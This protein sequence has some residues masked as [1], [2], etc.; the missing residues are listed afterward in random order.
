MPIAI[1]DEQL[2]I[3]ASI[4]EWAKRAGTIELVR[5]LEPGGRAD[6]ADAAAAERWSN[7]AD[8]GIFS[9]GLLQAAA[10]DA[11]SPAELAAALAQ[12]T[13]SLVPG[14]VMPTLL[15][16]LVLAR[17]QAQRPHPAL[18][19]IAGGDISV[20]TA[21]E[22]GSVRAVGR[23]DG[24]LALTGTT[25]PIL[26][27]GSTTHV[28][29]GAAG[30]DPGSTGTD[31]GTDTTGTDTTGT[32]TTGTD[33]TG[34]DTVG[35]ADSGLWFLLPADHPGI[36]ISC[37]EPADFSRTLAEVS[38]A[39]A[40]A[41]S[42]SLLPG[43]TTGQVRDLAAALASVE[44]AAVANW[45]CRTAAEYAAIRQQF[46]R[47]IG[48][49]QAVKHLCAT[50]FC[51]AEAA[52]VLAWD[53]ARA[54][55]QAPDEF[56]LAAAAAAAFS[57]DAAVDNAKDC[58]QVLGG[59]GFTWEHDAHL[60]LR[61]AIAVRQLM[62]GS[63]RWRDK[64]A[65]LATAGVRRHLTVDDSAAASDEFAELRRTAREVATKIA[66]LPPAKHR[67]ALAD[68]GYA[69]PSWPAPYGL[70][71]PPAAGLVIDAELARAGLARPE[72]VIGG[73]AV[74]AILGHG[75]QAQQ[76]RFAGPTLGGEIT[77]CQLFSEPE[78]GSDLAALR[79]RAERADGGWL[80]TGQKVWT[81]LAHEADWGI[82]L[83]RT[84]ATVPK[85]KGLSYFLVAMD[86]PGIETRPLREITGRE[87]FNQVFLDQV[88]VPDDC[89]VGT[90]GEGWRIAR[91]TL[92]SERVAMGAGSS[93][94]GAVEQILERAA[95][96][97]AAADP[98]FRQQL[99]ALVAEGMA[100][101]L[102]D[103]QAV[104]AQLRGAD[105]GPL[106]AVRKL[107][108][109]AHRQSAAEA[110]L[111]LAGPDGAAVDGAAALLVHEFLL[112]RCLSIAGGTTQILLSLVAERLLGLPREEAP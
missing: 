23:T 89:L 109:V 60:Y 74:P 13:E 5:S 27:G 70:A 11:G 90:P 30:V 1:T 80:L 37:R 59:I 71:A 32:D 64:A 106:A 82:C 91:T 78:A 41:G 10:E 81:S 83:A 94:G 97:P 2:A 66:G 75:S 67:R 108:G 25:A 35:D 3:Q 53:A 76:A 103:L 100:V 69:A 39:G 85:H 17:C 8:L 50:M 29:I 105:P 77:W 6:A 38:L 58:V 68:S 96:D 52:A 31:P 26:G 72:M 15:A 65:T 16:G 14:P 54:M 111:E 20:A 48:S 99:G 102:L 63:A 55:G 34:T 112:T 79:T 9:I 33:T 98:T 57:L 22:P 95:S 12:V 42:D 104:L 110:A 107:A 19:A 46:G 73:W 45:C 56:A 87:M 84:D 61:R 49:F 28:L 86:S 40:I 21:F 18:A 92:A 101:S 43:I 36:T 51:R 93:V 44:A 24:T 7:L 47:P 62:G 4:R 88:F